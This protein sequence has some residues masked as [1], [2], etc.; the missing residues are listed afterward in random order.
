[1]VSVHD[2]LPITPS[3]SIIRGSTQMNYEGIRERLLWWY[4]SLEEMCR[5]WGKS[6]ARGFTRCLNT[7]AKHWKTYC[8]NS[9]SV[10]APECQEKRPVMAVKVRLIPQGQ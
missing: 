7:T 8:N 3:E 4:L 5:M 6:A 9:G 1:M 10:S 2:W